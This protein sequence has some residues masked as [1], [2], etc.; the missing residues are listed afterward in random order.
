MIFFYFILTLSQVSSGV[1]QRVHDVWDHN[2]LNREANLKIQL[3]SIKPDN[4]KIFKNTKQCHS[5]FFV[6]K[7]IIIF[8]KNMHLCQHVMVLLLLFLNELINTEMFLYFNF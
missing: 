4:K 6:L 8:P 2:G 3:S 5:S 7:E 1:F